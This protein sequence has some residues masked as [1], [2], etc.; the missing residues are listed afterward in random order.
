MWAVIL[1]LL[2]CFSAASIIMN[3]Y[4]LIL[5][6][7]LFCMQQIEQKL[8]TQLDTL[9]LVIWDLTERVPYTLFLY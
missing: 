9:V 6:I 8:L 7:S 4:M 1:K 2:A 3:I 5:K